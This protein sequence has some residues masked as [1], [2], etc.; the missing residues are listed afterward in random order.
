MSMNILIVDDEKTLR[1]SMKLVLDDEGYQ[2][3]TSSDGLEA[4]DLIKNESFD[5]VI[6]D[7]K[8]EAIPSNIPLIGKNLKINVKNKNDNMHINKN[9]LFINIRTCDYLGT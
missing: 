1:D 6:T 3:K 9:C 7:I 4:L 2:T 8:P 5:V